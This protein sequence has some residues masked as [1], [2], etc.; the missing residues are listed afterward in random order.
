[1]KTYNISER[2]AFDPVGIGQFP[3]QKRPCVFFREENGDVTPIAT[4]KDD[5]AAHRLATYLYD[6]ITVRNDHESK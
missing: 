5:A 4:L 1:M 6:V 3:G 2:P